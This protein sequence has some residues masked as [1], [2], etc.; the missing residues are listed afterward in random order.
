MFIFTYVFIG[1]VLW[2]EK[3]DIHITMTINTALSPSIFSK[4]HWVMNGRNT[5]TIFL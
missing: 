3:I 5:V 2:H 1:D 4:A